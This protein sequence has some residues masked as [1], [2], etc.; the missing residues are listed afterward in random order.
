VS[1]APGSRIGPYE[2]VGPLGAGGMGEVYRA[3]D[4][5]LNRDVAVKALPASAALD[6]DRV[7]RFERE[8]QIL[9]ALNHP[10]IAAL[11]GIEDVGAHEAATSRFIVLELLEGGTLA[12]RLRRGPLPQRDVLTIARQVADAL[13]AAH[14]KGVIHRDIKPANLAFT[15]DGHAKILDF[16][17]AKTFVELPDA[18]TAALGHTHSGTVLGTAAYMSPEQ[19]R[20]LPVDKRSDIWAFGCILYEMLT[21]RHPFAAPSV[22]DIVARTLSDDPDWTLLPAATPERV[23]WLLRRCLEKDPRRRLHDIADARIELDEVLAGSGIGP[24]LEASA[25]AWPSRLLTPERLAWTAVVLALGATTVMALRGQWG[26]TASAEAGVRV[27]AINLPAGTQM[28][29]PDPA[30]FALSPDGKRLAFAAAT[31]DGPAMLWLRGLDS[32]VAQELPGTEGASHPFWSPDSTSIGFS[33]RPRAD[34]A[35]GRMHLKRLDLATGRITSITDVTFLATAAWNAEDVI[36]FTPAG[37]AP[38]HRTKASGGEPVPV[39]ALDRGKGHVQHSY[40]HFL[41]DGRTYLYTAVGTTTGGATDIEGVYAHRL[42][43]SGEPRLILERASHARHADGYLLYVQ[44]NGLFAQPFDPDTLELSGRATAVAERL[45][46]GAIGGGVSAAFTVSG[47]GLL[48][49]QTSTAVPSQ[50]RWFSRDGTPGDPV[51]GPADYGDLVLS[52][53]G[54]RLATS[55]RDPDGTARDIWTVDLARNRNL[56]EQ[57]TSH[58]SEEYAPVWSAKGDALAY[59][60]VREGS[61][62]LYRQVPG[63][64]EE[65]LDQSAPGLGKF[66]ASWSPDGNWI[67][68]IAGAR[69]IA[70]SDLMVLPLAGDRKPRVFAGSDFV[71]TQARFSPDGRWIAYAMFTAAGSQVYVNSFP[72]AGQPVRV[73]GNGGGWPH[74]NGTGTELYYLDLQ[75]RINVATVESSTGSFKVV[76]VRPLFAVPVQRMGR[77]DAYPYDVT[78]DGTR[79]LVST[80]IGS[81]LPSTPITFITNWTASLRR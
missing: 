8:A 18:E 23:T 74:W 37:D 58:P 59:T 25:P 55:I 62:D 50:L 44:G 26:R 73:S 45:L 63:G 34:L 7:G 51:G 72:E 60:A 31:G 41:P 42:D 30:R 9:A 38:L 78:P 1:L 12:D 13:H 35:G 70:R 77:L 5:R 28:A 46:A 3:R 67:L 61:V 75:R 53:D 22:T 52:P 24:A 66:A 19:A 2:I 4:P 14:E 33:V 56:F 6:A 54:T 68:Y 21:G 57:A 48:A 71:E 36:L 49:Y 15:A 10:H 43:A 47:T 79:F 65:K 64:G 69:T 20:G 80:Q 17:L 29:G 39:T 27:T 81:D 32:P 11:Y 40:P 16:G 76:E